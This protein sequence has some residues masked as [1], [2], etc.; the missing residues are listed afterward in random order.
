MEKFD[1]PARDIQNIKFIERYGVGVI[2]EGRGIAVAKN[3]S[4]DK[5][6]PEPLAVNVE[7]VRKVEAKNENSSK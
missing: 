5:S 4:I 6:Y 2:H 1:E 7:C 3:I